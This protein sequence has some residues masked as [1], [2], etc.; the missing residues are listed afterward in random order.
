QQVEENVDL[1]LSEFTRRGLPLSI[2]QQIRTLLL[3]SGRLPRTP[4]DFDAAGMSLDAASDDPY[5]PDL[6]AALA[7]NAN[8]NRYYLQPFWE[9]VGAAIQEEDPDAIVIFEGSLGMDDTEGIFGALITPM[10]A[11]EGINQYA[12]APHFYTDVYSV[13]GLCPNPDPRDFTVD[14]IQMRDYTEG[15]LSAIKL[16]AFSL[17][18]PPVILGEFGTYFNFGGIEKS[19]ELDYIVSAHMLNNYYEVLDEQMINRTVW[20]YSPENTAIDGEGWNKEDFSI[21]GPD[22]RPRG[23]DAYSRAM[24]RFTSGRLLSFHYNSP[25]DYYEPRPGVPTPYREFVL[26]MAGLETQAPTEITVPPKP[27]PDGFYVYVSDGR[28][29]FDNERHILYWFP[30]DDNPDATHTLRLRPPWPDYG[31]A[32]WDYFFYEDQVQEGVR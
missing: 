17:G 20:C 31:D 29:A 18:N 4:D 13:I 23:D 12:F 21:L 3:T 24:P 28:C 26:E 1:A 32:E 27:Y 10:L 6:G 5:R 2:V 25:L 7:L 22:Q 16:A 11:P 19:M 9:H 8:F 30:S 14:E 15:I